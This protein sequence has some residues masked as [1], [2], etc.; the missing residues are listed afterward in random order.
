MFIGFGSFTQFFSSTYYV[1]VKVWDDIGCQLFT[2]KYLDLHTIL[3]IAHLNP[4]IDSRHLMVLAVNRKAFQYNAGASMGKVSNI[5][6][7]N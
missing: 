1:T 2:C 7:D 6:K 5:V 3:N 4:A